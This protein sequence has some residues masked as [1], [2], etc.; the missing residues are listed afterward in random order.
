MGPVSLSCDGK[1]QQGKSPSNGKVQPGL[2][3]GAAKPYLAI[4][5]PSESLSWK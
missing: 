1:G 2:L 4:L 3:H 5:A